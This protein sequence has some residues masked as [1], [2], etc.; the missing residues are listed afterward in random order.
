M[1]TLKKELISLRLRNTD[2]NVQED[3]EADGDIVV[4]YYKYF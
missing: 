2:P 1:S 4:L 3:G